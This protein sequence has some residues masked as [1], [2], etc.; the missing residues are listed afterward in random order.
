MFKKLSFIDNNRTKDENIRYNIIRI[1]C[2][3]KM[4]FKFVD[5]ISSLNHSVLIK[6]VLTGL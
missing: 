3:G 6:I 4:W 5:L 1:S 2:D